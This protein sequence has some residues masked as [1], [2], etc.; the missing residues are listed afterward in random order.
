MSLGNKIALGLLCGS[1]PTM[2]NGKPS[3]FAKF[4]EYLKLKLKYN[5]GTC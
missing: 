3:D 4:L 2:V 1:W 5:V